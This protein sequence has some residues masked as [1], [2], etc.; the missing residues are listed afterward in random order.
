MIRSSPEGSVHSD[1]VEKV[2]KEEIQKE[3]IE[4]KS[5]ESYE[6][7]RG[8]QEELRDQPETEL[9]DQGAAKIRA[10]TEAQTINRKV[11]KI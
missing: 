8:Y 4:Q 9:A 5:D 6:S 7:F 10:Q 3:I 1:K 2:E 11:N